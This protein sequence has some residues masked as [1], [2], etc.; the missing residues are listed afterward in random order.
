MLD[1]LH[2][3]CTLCSN[4]TNGT[5][6]GDSLESCYEMALQSSRPRWRAQGASQDP[7]LFVPLTPTR[8]LGDT[9]GGSTLKER[10]AAQPPPARRRE[11]GGRLQR[12]N[13]LS[14]EEGL[15]MQKHMHPKAAKGLPL[16]E[17][18]GPHSAWWIVSPGVTSIGLTDGRAL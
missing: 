10:L 7:S 18:S 6:G 13:F 3:L 4:R 11:K 15:S 5:L 1:R 9:N 12:I 16:K 8:L 17:Y 2:T 14:H